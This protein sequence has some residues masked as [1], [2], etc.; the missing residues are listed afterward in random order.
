MHC[1]K[2]RSRTVSSTMSP[3]GPHQ[4][5]GD[6]TRGPFYPVPLLSVCLQLQAKQGP[7]PAPPR[8]PTEISALSQAWYHG[9]E[10]PLQRQNGHRVSLSSPLQPP[11]FQI[12]YLQITPSGW[13]D[14]TVSVDALRSGKK[15][16]EGKNLQTPSWKNI[17]LYRPKGCF[18]FFFKVSL[19]VQVLWLHVQRR[20]GRN[21]WN[22][23]WLC[24]E[25]RLS[26]VLYCASSLTRN[27]ALSQS[28]LM[29]VFFHILGFQTGYKSFL[30]LAMIVS[31]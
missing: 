16:N 31:P 17:Y 23:L 5:P 28:S 8:W 15:R 2:D 3:S 22:L 29:I 20:R 26:H 12:L 6:G 18:R 10:M 25:K 14:L 30:F 27:L 21:M 7:T 4:S 9:S 11:P 1:R 24:F 19:Q 13:G